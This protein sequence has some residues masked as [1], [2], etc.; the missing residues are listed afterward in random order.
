MRKIA[1]PRKAPRRSGGGP[2]ALRHSMVLAAVLAAGG[3]LASAAAA[4]LI[5]VP[6]MAQESVAPK[7]IL[8][9]GK[10]QGLCADLLAAIEAIEPRLRF[11]GYDRPRSLGVIEDALARG[12]VWAACALVDSPA[13]RRIAVPASV[14]LYEA[15]Y[16]L[17]AAVGDSEAVRSLEELAQRKQLVNTPRGSGYIA[18]LR[19]R[20]IDVDD[21]TGDSVT[22][23]RKTMHGHGRYTYM[24]E[25]SMLYYMR[26]EQFEGKLVVLPAVFSSG[27]LYFWTSKRADPTLAPAIEA[28]LIK[29]RANGELARIYARWTVAR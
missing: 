13:R 17:A 25:A 10:P 2:A 6:M 14:P 11:V 4:D 1:D 16:R 24:N 26:A 5:T 22:N 23:L 27:W 12:T 28:A 18:D 21:S 19:A 20:G 3:R 29:L 15:R 8:G 7:W 9:Q